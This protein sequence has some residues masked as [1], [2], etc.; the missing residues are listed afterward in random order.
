MLVLI[1]DY[2]NLV[3]IYLSIRTHVL[4]GPDAGAES[5]REKEDHPVKRYLATFVAAAS[6]LGTAV[7][8]AAAMPATRFQVTFNGRYINFDVQ[9]EIVNDRTFVPFRAIFEKMGAEVSFDAA[10]KTVSATRDGKEV[11]LQIGSSTGYV[12]GASTALAAAPY[13]KDDRT[14]IPLRFVSEAFGASV[15]YNEF[16]DRGLVKK[17]EINDANWPKRGGTLNLA[18]YDKPEGKF[19]PIVWADVY[20]SNI[21][22]LLYDSLFKLDESF[23]P[24]PALAES[25]EWSEGDTKL[26]FHLRKGATF[27]DGTPITAKDFVFTYKAIAHPKYI[28]PR[29]S[30][31]E[32]VLGWAEYNKGQK[33]ETAADFEAGIVT[34]QNIDGVYAEDDL[35][36]VFKLDKPNAAFFLGNAGFAAVDRSKY[37]NIPVQDWGTAKDPNNIYPN[38]SGPFMMDTYAE[39][40]YASL[41]A[42]PNY[43]NGKAYMDGILYRV[44]AADVAIGEMKL[45]NLD[46]V[47]FQDPTELEAYNAMSHVTVHE[48]PDLAFQLMWF[49]TKDPLLSDKEMR[50]AIAYAIDRNAIIHNLM[51]DHATALYQPIPPVLWAYTEDVEHYDYNP[52]KAGEILDSLGWKKGADGFR[53]K[54]GKKLTI[55]LTYPNTGNPVRIKTAPVVQKFLQDVGIDLQLAGY[56]RVTAFA[57]MTDEHDYQLGFMGFTLSVEPDPT[58]IWDKASA[59]DGGF[60]VA[61]WWTDTSEELIAKGKATGDIEKRIEIYNEWSRHWAD[62]LPAYLFYSPNAFTAGNNRIGNFK[63]STVGFLWNLEDLYLK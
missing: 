4:I 34:D 17:I 32:D 13:I 48:Y 53:Y 24:L 6:V 46:V 14:M 31:F 11:K 18:L 5:S 59:V 10:T 61:Q 12:N 43:Y 35:T 58:G 54:D 15:S 19:N 52:T 30:G 49:N 16:Q 51:G 39:G 29:N 23:Q 44:V 1:E 20:S 25:W 9:P 26:T 7:P 2:L 33:G 56:D 60:N 3:R 40:Q 28:G 37:A 63:P 27:F 38:G 55:T 62:E 45:G 22:G 57:K 47:E 8:A 41:K 50:H 36:L 21:G 42:N